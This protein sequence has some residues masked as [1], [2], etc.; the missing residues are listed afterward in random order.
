MFR[1][2]VSLSDIINDFKLKNKNL[3]KGLTF[4]KK[5]ELKSKTCLRKLLRRKR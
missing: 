1:N 5:I 3:R 4:Y 2:L